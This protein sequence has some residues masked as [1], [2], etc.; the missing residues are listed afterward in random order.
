MLA[1]GPRRQVSSLFN[2]RRVTICILVS[3]ICCFFDRHFHV[4]SKVESLCKHTFHTPRGKDIRYTCGGFRLFH[5]SHEVYRHEV[6]RNPPDRS[7]LHDY[8]KR[9][10]EQP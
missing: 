2:K 6:Y 4:I 7:F 10:W 1:Q 5:F 8:M 3:V 9:R